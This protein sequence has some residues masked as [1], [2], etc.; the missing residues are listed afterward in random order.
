MPLDHF[1]TQSASYQTQG[2]FFFSL[3][4]ITGNGLIPL[5]VVSAHL[6]RNQYSRS[7]IFMNLCY[8]LIFYSTSFLLSFYASVWDSPNTPNPGWGLCSLQ[9]VLVYV[10]TIWASSCSFCLVLQLWFAAYESSSED[11]K[12]QVWSKGIRTAVLSL[13]PYFFAA[14]FALSV[15]ITVAA[16]PELVGLRYLFC[17]IDLEPLRAASAIFIFLLLLT[18]LGFLC[19]A[20]RRIYTTIERRALDQKHVQGWKFSS[21]F[22]RLCWFHIPVTAG[23]IASILI[24]ASDQTISTVARTLIQAILPLTLWLAFGTNPALYL[25]DG[26]TI[27][28][29]TWRRDE[30]MSK[31]EPPP[32]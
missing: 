23:I 7:P 1:D 19:D 3:L 4:I 20:G 15:S 31:K 11:Q 30:T 6:S 27:K 22:L 29:P 18:T 16:R 21:L 28:W 26:T 2:R 24:V 8:S 14:S 12:Q 10:G 9:T 13:V 32:V 5:M 17:G 25:P